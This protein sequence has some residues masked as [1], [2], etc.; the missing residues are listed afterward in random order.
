MKK[1]ISLSLCMLMAASCLQAGFFSNSTVAVESARESSSQYG[2]SLLVVAGV[3]TVA[4]VGYLAYK[5]FKKSPTPV[6]PMQDAQ[7]THP[8]GAPKMPVVNQSVKNNQHQPNTLPATLPIAEQDQT[9]QP[10]YPSLELS[11]SP[12]ATTPATNS[13]VARELEQAETLSANLYPILLKTQ[14]QEAA[15]VELE[16][17]LI[18]LYYAKKNNLTTGKVVSAIKALKSKQ[19]LPVACMEYIILYEEALNEQQLDDAESIYNK[20]MALLGRSAMDKATIETTAK[21]KLRQLSR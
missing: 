20:F 16:T 1:F 18:T 15:V 10:L 11:I 12:Q 7:G 6:A 2:K 8:N 13:A 14:E 17:L 21:S 4:L 5:W 19:I 3:G 9:S